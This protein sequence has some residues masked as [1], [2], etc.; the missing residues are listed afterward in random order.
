MET[1]TWGLFTKSQAG[2]REIHKGF[3]RALCDQL[4]RAVLILDLKEAGGGRSVQTSES[5]FDPV[6]DAA[7]QHDLQGGS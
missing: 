5:K 3:Y 2:P 1:L 6:G 4:Q 7:N